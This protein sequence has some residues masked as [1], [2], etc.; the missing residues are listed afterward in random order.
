MKFKIKIKIALFCLSAWMHYKAVAQSLYF[1]PLSS[2][3]PWDTLSASSLGWCI[4]YV[5]SL[6]DFLDQ[7]NTKG[8]ILLKD[9]KIVLEKYFGTFT[10]DSLWYWAS[11]GKTIT[12]FLIGK[13][14]EENYLHI[15]DTTSDYL[16]TGWTSCS[17]TQEEKITIWNQLTMTTGLDDG[18]IDPYCT[19]DTCLICLTNPGL[20]WAYHNAPYTLLHQVLNNATGFSMNNYTNTRLKIKTGMSG[21]WVQ[22]G[23]NNVYYSNVRSM[24][25]FGLLA[26]NNFI[27]QNDT[28]LSDTIYKQ[29]MINTSQQLNLAYGY[30]WWL[31]GKNS[32]M[33]P[34]SQLVFPGWLAP[35]APQDMFAALGKDGQVLSISKG[36]GLV[37]ARMGN[38]PSGLV[39]FTICNDIWKILNQI[40]CSPSGFSNAQNEPVFEVLPNPATSILQ[41]KT[42][43]PQ[44]FEILIYELSGRMLLKH[45]NP[46]TIN[47]SRLS[48][49]CYLLFFNSG[50]LQKTIK[51]IKSF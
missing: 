7:N 9:G 40:I 29:Q 46:K 19:D 42:S 4:N 20:R 33:I 10:A 23:Y 26:Q 51:F 37:F 18:V 6:Y 5:D 27:W 21:F 38:S 2:S 36:N 13:A 41:V 44:D 8:F 35:N 34:G 30:L 31:N 50:T 25:R 49:G 16:G 24:A 48:P 47:I 45:T 22:L 17:L 28:L 14:Q 3:Q 11:A 15:T 12:A 39:P 1:P 32:F 43:V